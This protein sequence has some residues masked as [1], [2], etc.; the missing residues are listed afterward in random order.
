MKTLHK[1]RINMFDWNRLN[2]PSLSVHYYLTIS[3][4]ECHSYFHRIAGLKST[5]L[6]LCSRGL[7]YL[8]L[9]DHVKAK[10]PIPPWIW[11]HSNCM[12]SN[13]QLSSRRQ[14]RF[15]TKLKL[16]FKSSSSMETKIALL[17]FFCTVSLNKVKMLLDNSHQYTMSKQC[18]IDDG[19]TVH[20]AA[21]IYS[22][23]TEFHK[24]I[25]QFH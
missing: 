9:S 19:S 24:K 15:R 5:L 1:I 23:L 4:S 16:M 11:D 20:L 10:L 6:Q 14:P 13:I 18:R 7:V 8:L 17:I 25:I 12:L 2:T 21:K 3:L 22:T